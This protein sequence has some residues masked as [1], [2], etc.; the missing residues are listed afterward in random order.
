MS[1][2]ILLKKPKSNK[3]VKKNRTNGIPNPTLNARKLVHL[4]DIMDER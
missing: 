1:L 3:T 2:T 4:L